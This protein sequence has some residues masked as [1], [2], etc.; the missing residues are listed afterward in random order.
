VSAKLPASRDKGYR[1]MGMEGFFARWYAR[2]TANHLADYRQGAEGVAAQVS[3]GGSVLEVAPGP[4]YLAIELAKLGSYRVVGL[5]ISRSFVS[6]AT[7]NAGKAGVA[8]EF[9]R[10]NAAA[11]PFASD[12][13]DFIICRAAFKNFSEPV[14]ALCEMHRVLKVGGKSLI[15][16]LRPDAS[17]EA[18]A[19]EVKRMGLG[20]INA[21]ITRLIFKHMLIKRAYSQQ[22]FRDMTAQ[23]PFHT[24]QIDENP[25]GLAVSLVK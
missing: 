19:S 20:T 3:D 6:M 15:H 23:T 14:Q 12:S 4:G 17:R 21:L 1:G 10:G 16:D 2:N 13:F 22:Q 18:I 11:M 25:L 5:D 8:V 7:E 9:E 24:C